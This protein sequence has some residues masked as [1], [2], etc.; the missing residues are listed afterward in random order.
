LERKFAGPGGSKYRKTRKAIL[1]DC[2]QRLFVIVAVIPIV[3]GMPVSASP[4]PTAQTQG[5]TTPDATNNRDAADQADT[6][7]NGADLTRPQNSFETRLND[8]TSSSPTSQTKRDT[9]ILRLNSKVTFD[10]GW[11]LATLAQI[12][13]VAESTVTFDPSGSDQSFGLGGTV[14]QTILARAVDERWAFGVGAR[15]VARSVSDDVG[16]G[17]WQIMPGFGVRY[18]IPEWGTDSYFVPAV[19][20]AMS[21]AGDQ[22]ARRISEPQIAPTLNIDLPAAGF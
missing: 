8:Q 9:L 12:P 21:F 14:F 6:S 17:K 10:D 15:F 4:L 13:V 1:L 19:R 16:N 18:S 5:S 3:F 11:K 22:A 20:Y 7:N 2:A